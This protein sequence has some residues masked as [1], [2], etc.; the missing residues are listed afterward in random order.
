MPFDTLISTDDLAAHLGD[1]DWAII[2]CRCQLKDPGYGRREYEVAH[3]PGA[4]F[5]DLNDDLSGPLLPG[6]TGRHPLP[7]VEFAAG[8][9]STWGI[10]GKIQVV[11]YDDQGGALAAAR[12]WWMLHWLSHDQV[13]VLD[14]GWQKWQS[15]DRPVKSG[16]ETRPARIFVARARPQL[17]IT[18]RDVLREFGDPNFRLFD[19]RTPE[20]FRG[21]IEPIDPV[22]GHIPGAVSIPYAENLTPAGTFKPAAELRRLYQPF[23]NGLPASQTAFYCGSGG[24]APHSIL[25]MLHAGLGEARLYAGSWSEWITDPDHPIA[26]G[27]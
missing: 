17:A 4:V 12:L 20:R 2:D 7:T 8:L 6:K 23:L 16:V 21:E 5:A 14:G 3:I 27:D 10:N 24:T 15:E 18:A 13:A 9:F 1:P 19:V 26:R 22:A 25:A 11:A